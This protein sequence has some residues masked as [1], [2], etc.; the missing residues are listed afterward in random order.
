MIKY[1]YDQRS[2]SI[3]VTGILVDILTSKFFLNICN[4]KFPETLFIIYI[5]V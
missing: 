5:Y 2:N 3:L 4:F 1:Q